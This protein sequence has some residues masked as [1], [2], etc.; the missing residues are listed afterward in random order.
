MT[1]PAGW[2][3]D[4]SGRQ[5]WWDGQQWTE[6]FAPETTDAPA[7][8]EEHLVV[9]EQVADESIAPA[10][11]TPEETRARLERDADDK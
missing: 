10:V 6:H 11:E 8:S 7:V 1:T 2:S 5:R 3:D 9:E 4:G